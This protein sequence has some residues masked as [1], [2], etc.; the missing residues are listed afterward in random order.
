MPRGTLHQAAL[1][2]AKLVIVKGDLQ[3][4][5]L[6]GNLHW[7]ATKPHRRRDRAPTRLSIIARRGPRIR[8]GQWRQAAVLGSWLP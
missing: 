6:I 1:E 8:E 3:Y 5:K 7:C 4:R 2:A